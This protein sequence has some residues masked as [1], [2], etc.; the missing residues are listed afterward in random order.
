MH[1]LQ[2]LLGGIKSESING[3]GSSKLLDKV[4]KS[5]ATSHNTKLY[6]REAE[7]RTIKNILTSNAACNSG[8]QEHQNKQSSKA[9]IIFVSGECGTGK[10][11]LIE[12]AIHK[13]S[14]ARS[15]GSKSSTTFLVGT[16]SFE[17]TRR[18]QRPQLQRQG[19]LRIQN[20]QLKH[21]NSSIA[22][23]GGG[24]KPFHALVNSLGDIVK[25]MIEIDSEYYE[26]LILHGSGGGQVN[27]EEV[28]VGEG[29]GKQGGGADLDSTE[30]SGRG[31]ISL[32]PE[33]LE[34]L[35][36]F[37]PQL[38]DLIDL[39]QTLQRQG[40]GGVSASEAGAATGAAVSNGNS[41]SISIPS[42]C[43]NDSSNSHSNT[44]NGRRTRLR[45]KSTRNGNSHGGSSG[46]E[47]LKY[48]LRNFLRLISTNQERPV[49][50]WLDDLQWID[51]STLH[52][53]KN[54]VT[55]PELSNFIF[56]GSYRTEANT[57][58]HGAYDDANLSERRR[59][60]DDSQ[61]ESV[62]S[63][64]DNSHPL[65]KWIEE[66][67]AEQEQE[68]ARLRLEKESMAA[69]R[70]SIS[71]SIS[72]CE[73]GDMTATIS[74]SV[75]ND[76]SQTTG[77]AMTV[78]G[79]MMMVPRGIK[80]TTGVSCHLSCALQIVCHTLTPLTEVLQALALK[81][82]Q[83]RNIETTAGGG[84]LPRRPPSSSLLLEF[85]YFFQSLF[86]STT[87]STPESLGS[88]V[89]PT[90]FYK[91]LEASELSINQHDVG[92]ASNAAY[93]I[94]ELVF[95]QSK[96]DKIFSNH[97]HVVDDHFVTLF[98]RYELSIK[99]LNTHISRLV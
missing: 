54:L 55:D 26:N 51:L 99:F 16:G 76:S 66:L 17:Q 98:V 78:G 96:D 88:A 48:V 62:G 77:N 59:T 92:D 95:R 70:T 4:D 42:S 33:D 60:G 67:E 52:V 7:L 36:K 37:V 39:R 11:T 58:S 23:G 19:A 91:Y 30:R 35:M 85:G 94:L 84:P 31:S 45:N 72:A 14:S 79:G 64:N 3:G 80:N 10:T 65:F 89:D 34:I 57:D 40:K 83:Q 22:N 90:E 69:T 82:Q 15:S 81:Q 32:T 53:V 87:A 5:P 93:K 24:K 21:N 9:K 75:D 25:Q 56:I 49:V 63:S 68:Q 44:I 2:A 71:S 46:L 61:E 12:Q 74:A 1:G 41:S 73:D 50:L 38:E 86:C 18:P 28:A 13:A 20:Q 47:V 97:Q 8:H 29:D 27:V 43:S 6:G